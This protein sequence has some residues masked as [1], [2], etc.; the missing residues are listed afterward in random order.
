MVVCD[1]GLLVA[2]STSCRL[3]LPHSIARNCGINSECCMLL[4]VRGSE[5]A[6]A[7]LPDNFDWRDKGAV[8]KV[9]QCI[10]SGSRVP[11]KAH[12]KQSHRFSFRLKPSVKLLYHTLLRGCSQ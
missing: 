3:S 1:L 4:D 7:D 11:I 8:T 12:T 9:I 2:L 5:L 6:T 10:T